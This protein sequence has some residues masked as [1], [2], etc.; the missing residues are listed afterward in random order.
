M[1]T[2]QED[3]L[4]RIRARRSLV[5]AEGV[6]AEDPLLQ[7]VRGRRA[8]LADVPSVEPVG[9]TP[10]VPPVAPERGPGIFE[11]GRAA[12]GRIG[13][14]LLSP[15]EGPALPSSFEKP[16]G[17]VLSE[18]EQRAAARARIRAADVAPHIEPAPDVPDAEPA[19]T[20]QSGA[21]RRREAAATVARTRE[22]GE[23][24][25]T[26]RLGL[27]RQ[28]RDERRAAEEEDV[29]AYAFSP[30]IAAERSGAGI[31][32][33][34]KVGGKGIAHGSLGLLED[35]GVVQR[36][37]GARLESE[38][39]R[40]SGERTAAF[41]EEKAKRYELP[42]EMQGA[43]AD[44]PSLMLDPKWL[45]YGVA[46]M[47]PGMGLSV[48]SGVGAAKY[49]KVGG[50]MLS[51]TPELIA[52]LAAIGGAIGGGVVGGSLE[53]AQT[54][55][56][57]ADLTGDEDKAATAAELMTLA[58]GA[59]NAISLG[60][61]LNPKAGT[62]ALAFLR[63]VAGTGGL[64]AATE[65]LEEPAEV[66]IKLG[67][68]EG[69][70]TSDMAK[71]QLRSGLNVIP[72]AFITGG[73][74]GV[75]GTVIRRQQ[76][77][78]S[79]EEN[80][81]LYEY[82]RAEEAGDTEAM[83]RTAKVL[84]A[85]GVTIEPLE[86]ST[87]TEA[88][89]EEVGAE[90]RPGLR[91]RVADLI[92]PTRKA[93]VEEAY[94]DPMTGLPN[95][96]AFE[97]TRE[98]R[99]DD[100][101]WH[102]GS[103]D[104]VEFKPINDIL[105][106]E[107][108]DARLAEVATII[109]EE[110][111][112]RGIDAREVQ[113]A[114][115]D[116]FAVWGE[117]EAV[118]QEV[119]DAAVAR[120]PDLQAGEFTSRMR[121][122]V[123]AN[124]LEA[125]AATQ[126][127]KEE[128]EGPKSRPKKP[129]TEAEEVAAPEPEPEDVEAEA[130][131][132]VEKPEPEAEVDEAEAEPDAVQPGPDEEEAR[133]VGE[134]VPEE[135]AEEAV[136]EAAAPT[137]S[138]DDEAAI[139]A[140]VE[141]SGAARSIDAVTKAR[142]A[143]R[144]RLG[145]SAG[146][147]QWKAI[148]AESR[149]RSRAAATERAE[150]EA[151]ALA[152]RRE[153]SKAD[154]QARDDRKAELGA[155]H[156]VERLGELLKKGDD[157]TVAAAILSAVPEA[158]R[159]EV[160]NM[161]VEAAE[162]MDARENLRLA[163]VEMR[164]REEREAQAEE[165]AALPEEEEEVAPE[166]GPEIA[167]EEEAPPA[168][169]AEAESLPSDFGA[170]NTI[171]TPDDMAILEARMR[172]KLKGKLR[173]VDPEMIEIGTKMTVFYVEGGVRK[174][175]DVAQRIADRLG[176]SVRS[177]KPYLRSWYNAT[178]DMLE[179]SDMDVSD[180]DSADS[181][182]ATVT[183]LIEAEETEDAGEAE[184]PSDGDTSAVEGDGGGVP[185]GQE[186]G[187]VPE[188]QEGEE[189]PGVSGREGAVGEPGVRD[190]RPEAAEGEPGAADTGEDVGARDGDEGRA[191]PD[192][193]GETPANTPG[194]IKGEDYKLTA[195]E[196]AALGGPKTRA[197][198]NIAAII[199]VKKL[200]E[201]GRPATRDEQTELAKYVGWGGLKLA[202]PRPRYGVGSP[203]RG[204][205][206]KRYDDE[207]WEALNK[208][209]RELL[210]DE[211]YR[212]AKQSVQYAHYTSPTVVAA[213][214]EALA[215]LGVK[216][217]V[218]AMEPGAGVGNFI[219][220]SPLDATWTAIEK[221]ATT[222]S[223]LRH[224][225]PSV[226]LYPDP[227]Q[228]VVLPDDRQD[229]IVGNPPF[230][231][232]V[233]ADS[234][235]KKPKLRIHDYFFMKSLDKLR[236]GGVLAFVTSTGTMDKGFR[237]VRTALGAKADF[238]GAIRLPGNAFQKTA[239]T[240]V[241]TDI[242]FFRKRAAGEV[243][244][245]AAEWMGTGEVEVKLDKW[246]HEATYKVNEYFLAHPEMVLGKWA[247]DKLTGTRA[248][249]VARRGD[250]LEALLQEA[251]QQLPE[252]VYVQPTTA[253]AAET[254]E[255]SPVPKFARDGQWIV[256]G[257][258]VMEVREG[259]LVH[260]KKI[261][262]RK[263]SGARIVKLIKLGEAAQEVFEVTRNNG[264]NAELKKAQRKL[265]KL[266]DTFVK[267]HGP[268]NLERQRKKLVTK[269][270]LTGYSDGVNGPLVR[271]LEKYDADTGTATKTAIHTER[272]F[273]DL[274][275]I[276][277]VDTAWK[278]VVASLTEYGKVDMAYMVEA[279][280]KPEEE[281]VG[282]L[283]GRIFQN[284]TTGTYETAET[285]LSGNV[286]EKL[287]LAKEWAEKNPRYNAN[288]TA[289]EGV[290]P[291]DV[292]ANQMKDQ[293]A[294]TVGVSWI[295]PRI[296]S[297]FI[298]E[299][300]GL[301]N[302]GIAY[303]EVDGRWALNGGT[304]DNAGAYEQWS[305]AG[306][307]GMTGAAAG[308]VPA[309]QLFRDMLNSRQTKVTYR[310]KEGTFELPEQTAA[311]E[312]MKKAMQER[313]TTWA[314]DEL[315]GRSTALHRRYND[316]MNHTVLAE[317]DG[318]HLRDR[319]PGIASQFRG[320]PLVLADH[321]LSAAWR[322]LAD[323][324]LLMAHE[325]GAGKTMTMAIIAMEAKRMGLARKPAFAVPNSV[326]NQ[327]AAEIQEVY[328]GAKILVATDQNFTK[329]QRTRFMA[330]VAADDWDAVIFSHDNLIKIPTTPE[331]ERGIIND[332]IAEYQAALE[333]AKADG[334]ARFTVAN[335]EKALEKYEEKLAGMRLTRKDN[336]VYWEDLGIDLLQVDEAHMFKNLPLP[337]TGPVS[338]GR[339]D[340]ATD[341]YIKSRH[342]ENVNP[343]RG[344]VFATATPI[345]NKIA[346]MYAMMRYLMEPELKAQGYG[347]LNSWANN[348]VAS[349]SEHE[350][351]AIG[352]LKETYRPRAYSNAFS[353]A[354]MFRSVA[355]VKLS[356]HLSLDVPDL[357]GGEAEMVIVPG[358]GRLK[359]FMKSLQRRWETRPKPQKEGDDGVFTIMNDGRY[360][361]IDARNVTSLYASNAGHDNSQAWPKD[362]AT[363]AAKRIYTI[364]K[365]TA[366]MKGTQMVFSDLAVPH[367]MRATEREAMARNL[368]DAMPHMSPDDIYKMI[369][370]EL[371]DSNYDVYNDIKDK[372][373][374]MGIPAAEIRF[375]QEGKNKDGKTALIDQFN[376]GKIRVM[377]GST[378]AMG[379]GVN[380]QRRMVA[381]HH[382]DVPY[383]PAWLAQREGRLI[384]QGNLLWREKKIQHVRIFRYALKGSYDPRAWQ[385]LENK[386]GFIS[387][388]MTA[389]ADAGMIDEI[390]DKTLSAK[391]AF[392]IIKAEAS[393]NPHAMPWAQ[394]EARMK[395][396][397]GA[398]R[399]HEDKAFSLRS[400][401]SW[402][403]SSLKF[404]KGLHRLA[405]L[406]QPFLVDAT[407]DNLTVVIDG[408]TLTDRDEIG[409]AI[410]DQFVEAAED[411]KA[412]KK[413]VV[414]RVIGEYAGFEL[415]ISI[416]PHGLHPTKLTLRL[417][418][419]YDAFPNIRGLLQNK[420]RPEAVT[421]SLESLVERVQ[422]A[423][424]RLNE[425][426][427]EKEA[428]VESMEATQDQPFEK[429]EELVE[430]TA[431]FNTL[432]AKMKAYSGGEGSWND[433]IPNPEASLY[434]KI[435][436]NM[437]VATTQKQIDAIKEKAKDLIAQELKDETEP[438][439]SYGQ[440]LRL[441][442][443]V[444]QADDALVDESADYDIEDEW[445]SEGSW[446]QDP[447]L[448]WDPG[449][450]P[451]D[452]LQSEPEHISS[453]MA[454][455]LE[456]PVGED[457]EAGVSA[458]A[459]IEALSKVTEAAGKRIKMG[460]GRLG[461]KRALGWW[462]PHTEVI[463]TAAANNIPTATHEVAHAIEQLLYGRD[464]GGPWKL[465]RASSKMQK[466]LVGLGRAL[467]GDRKPNGGYK[468]E[469]WAEFIRMWVTETTLMGR[470][471][472]LG[473]AAP[474]TLDWFEDTF[475][476]DHAEV[477][478]SLEAAREVNREWREQGSQS[479]ALASI[480]DP[481]SPA[482]RAKRVAASIMHFGSMEKLVEMA[483]PLHDLA[484][485]AEKQTGEKLERSEDPFFTLSALRT[486]HASRAARMV[487]HGMLDL[488]G[489]VV[490]PALNEIAPL[491]KRRRQ[492]FTI[493]LWAV[494]T[495]EE[496][497]NGE[498][499]DTGLSLADARQIEQEL[500]TPNFELA[501]GKV[502][503]WNSGVLDYAAQ[504]SPTFKAVV[505]AV[506]DKGRRYY[507]PLQREFEEMHNIWARSARKKGSGSKS[508]PVSR[509]KGSGRRLK[510]PF[511]AMISQAERTIR[512]AHER[513]VLDQI[514]KLSQI[515]GMGHLVEE[516]NL[517]Q[518]PVA[519]E[520]IEGLI[521]RINREIFKRDP[522]APLVGFDKD[523]DPVST[524]LTLSLITFFAPNERTKTGDQIV[525][526]MD[527]GRIRYFEVDGKLYDTLSSLDVYRLPDIA[528]FPILEWLGGKPAAAMRAGTTGL[529]ASFGLL[530]NPLK[531]VQTLYVN[532][533]SE[534]NG[535]RVFAGW[536]R[537]MGDMALSRTI[538]VQD[539]WVEAWM[540]LGG[541]MAQPLGQDIPHTRRA[542]RRLFE[543]RTE[544]L[545]DPRNWFDFYRDL[546]QFPEGAPRIAEM[547][548]VAKKVGWEPGQPMTLNQSL[549][550]LLASKQVTTDFTAAG[551]VAR[552]VNRMVPFH[553]AAIQG[554]RA[555]I[556]AAKRNPTKFVWHGLHLSM[557]TIFLWWMNKDE[558]WYK[559]MEYRDRFL[560]WFFPF[561]NPVTGEP[562]LAKIPRAFEVG[563]I[564]AALPEM[565][566]DSWYRSEPE[567]VKAWFDEFRK[568][569]TPDMTPV[570]VL[571]ALEQ[572]ANKD[573]YF[574]RPIV[575]MGELRRPPAE[576]FNAYTSRAAIVLGDVFD[577]APRR[578]DHAVRG[579]YGPVGADIL[580]LLGMGT[581]EDDREDELA[582]IPV[583]GR[584]FQR[585]GQTGT[586]PRPVSNLYDALERAQRHQASTRPVPDP[587]QPGASETE[588]QREARLQLN[589]ATKAVT[590]LLYVRQHTN[591]VGGRRT[592]MA[593]IV[594]IAK[595]ALETEE[596]VRSHFAD[597]RKYAEER[598]EIKDAELEGREPETPAPPGGRSRRGGRSRSRRR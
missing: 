61:M 79:E 460:V 447:D 351:T 189:A 382:I 324:N 524:D 281:I 211:E 459:V 315:E 113:R 185:E 385:I 477:Y 138:E 15:R 435:K 140:L 86:D 142:K 253:E 247:K 19:G 525:P 41:W 105:G 117:D 245:H 585:G 354:Q 295:E 510:D 201:E 430:A 26:E 57:I 283:E 116:E 31:E 340:K 18:Q 365:Q 413:P 199:L 298:D 55:K 239:A 252:N 198:Q 355:D 557:L 260:L 229:V 320:D 551:E 284:P 5:D 146:S 493:Y 575:P 496:Y 236:P 216:G 310:T 360:A 137:F 566:L 438:G 103:F 219:G 282:E 364:W 77:S 581:P 52:K 583:L 369:D 514:L 394:A 587:W 139:N 522:N 471:A 541:E 292:T 104:L 169:A 544:R 427:L 205:V 174:F 359:K 368:A 107:A 290:Q 319:L 375:I 505:D 109:Q 513:I 500:G 25:L 267:K 537:A 167:P 40:E 393:D 204:E 64:E 337:A 271:A 395:G 482:A 304:I 593:E 597:I 530:W 230:G 408:K 48:L 586:R 250:D 196:I 485:E 398:K 371:S 195:E 190:E 191:G 108:G 11:R 75:G 410:A 136:E 475:A 331:L 4:A 29:P 92:D 148:L 590:A 534:D 367:A 474:L 366:E 296:Y 208:E 476:V 423:P 434:E 488:K 411:S 426:V 458:P 468:R 443:L 233:I 386:I 358:S 374:E 396:L 248:G 215:R 130:P 161:A 560:H 276:G 178:R 503:E 529:R 97:K 519:R 564:F 444:E 220:L 287:A 308:S 275:E 545:V 144:A 1:S 98:R 521:E 266:Y 123:G 249:V 243:V 72:V 151:A 115:G 159:E 71:E 293:G 501:A 469:G 361:A 93:E 520:T 499:R 532:T 402:E 206:Y 334:E 179:D 125:E 429:E 483:Q 338:T 8:S 255:K 297:A 259:A 274:R 131:D 217:N 163:Y 13:S 584:L 203:G 517:G 186:P 417:S 356:E 42:E 595:D 58:S 547:R 463:R 512:Q 454:G 347:S 214:Y 162:S 528:G 221:D 312:R 27:L 313:F 559:D 192:D 32:E 518:K 461:T 87:I 194:I 212:L 14:A 20:G 578:I 187:G 96:S 175:A 251:I 464:R 50:Q 466:E 507:M 317:W 498:G 56:E 74:G 573:F 46:D 472:N 176:V 285:Y 227:Y 286:K 326:L 470:K 425:K 346:E 542:A 47:L 272:L 504:A 224:L 85:H 232:I 341:L 473:K 342:L 118:V 231:D 67:L 228:N 550:M 327:F 6:Q 582:D 225:Y 490:G 254:D 563:M 380:G 73:I 45:A 280:G 511:Q 397:Q 242:L 197:R 165:Q 556:R 405:E 2:R 309:I 486:T 353:M 302:V 433:A 588:N 80:A 384:R 391:E 120:L 456:T 377:I 200:D 357:K 183:A 299:V 100:L 90:E 160:A 508:S 53:G 81:A 350:F 188:A 38:G 455:T 561:D 218:R 37:L 246:P 422:L 526:I 419:T 591:D 168:E 318:S 598:R 193:V 63:E 453:R 389:R 170:K 467:Y 54:F 479:R 12:L 119:V 565:L 400:K 381:L 431:E 457:A 184:A 348:Y 480:V 158:D 110:A 401:V 332:L 436:A 546:V 9:D 209:L 465:P 60:K 202:F 576:Q 516:V 553:N 491:V 114:G 278:S 164:A 128:E 51:L 3:L 78:A 383:V 16:V 577:V 177:L 373:V 102:V 538:G 494:H 306:R 132:V 495:I 133:A 226:D 91:R 441:Y 291:Q 111:A 536:A 135:A 66:L 257:S 101:G 94:R 515:E 579:I 305:V 451:A 256:K 294:T 440:A 539:E 596:V 82:L 10:F 412:T 568:V 562:E 112:A 414:D 7:R 44:D 289:L 155:A 207:K 244:N 69:R 452:P 325:V 106:R 527:Q 49:I 307:G 303:R 222:S 264:T 277:K 316:M 270:N 210:T 65:Y 492:D 126:A 555:N 558:D 240:E 223:I 554:P 36:Y 567:Q 571:Q 509:F 122:A 399:Q 407:G 370:E 301:E 478:E 372:L 22:T 439:V 279:Y 95:Q 349:W 362:K 487:E 387:Q 150:V 531:D 33:I 180:M 322:Y 34:A 182:R 540:N 288:V 376:E 28:Q 263:P 418:G 403:K 21:A 323:G 145:V 442:S 594:A 484:R 416:M 141:A 388:A 428:A 121:G 379:Q 344:L 262:P 404:L 432:E 409:K 172:A 570:L 273:G 258:K 448:D 300:L 321:Q 572:A 261:D 238:L 450:R 333:E 134:E 580:G 421:A 552:I 345:S 269:P 23:D 535:L 569:A 59:L 171:V 268:I 502:L 330:Q 437:E 237:T 523:G 84:K 449:A 17:R 147:A 420:A 339:A 89:A 392:Q 329:A 39:L 543:G 166:P 88:E 149:E 462:N 533:Q 154:A 157:P 390:G 241:T 213:I 152:E 156:P 83:E 127:L 24:A 328:P 265:T 62:S 35:V 143:E 446:L 335:L 589:D 497:E 181:L 314:L 76:E 311:A 99:D 445:V 574:D 363:Y 234:R 343:G 235:Y 506:R 549:E 70:F 415:E 173:T 592:I 481:M 153:V 424:E 30:A 336:T 129:P 352:T 489:Q 68:S 548:A 406:D 378:S 43:I 124:W